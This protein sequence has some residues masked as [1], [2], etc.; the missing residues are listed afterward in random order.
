[1]HHLSRD[2]DFGNKINRQN[3]LATDLPTRILV[4]TIQDN[5]YY[6]EPMSVDFEFFQLKLY[7]QIECDSQ[8]KFFDVNLARDNNDIQLKSLILAQNE[9]WRHG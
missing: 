2:D 1:M 3:H 5:L 4:M 9:R 8:E 6:L 7:N